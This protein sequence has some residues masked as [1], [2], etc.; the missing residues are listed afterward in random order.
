[1]KLNNYYLPFNINLYVRKSENFVN[2]VVYL[3]DMLSH[4]IHIE[5]KITMEVRV[6]KLVNQILIIAC[7]CIQVGVNLLVLIQHTTCFIICSLIV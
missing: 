6:G 4:T 1:M 3:H 7:K 5:T 2:I